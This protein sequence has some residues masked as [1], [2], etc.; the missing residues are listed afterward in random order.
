MGIRPEA[1]HDDEMFLSTAT[2]GIVNANVEITEMMGAETFLY[3]NCAGVSLTARV[4][5]RSTAKSG[6]I[7]K[8]A[9]DPNK[10]HLFDKD[11]DNNPAIINWFSLSNYIAI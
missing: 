7:I 5:P 8:I 2:T 9:L 6:D 3:L 11:A 10:L 4:D 1:I